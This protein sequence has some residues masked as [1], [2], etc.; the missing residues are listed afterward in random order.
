[1]RDNCVWV[2]PGATHFSCLCE[3]CLDGRRAGGSSFLDAVQIASVRGAVPEDTDIAFV[4]CR[5]G[6][7]LVVRRVDRP[8]NLVRRDLR[9]L[10]IR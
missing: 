6:H 3:R 9:Q 7:E 8:P 4:R 1:M 10:Q 2:A 5:A